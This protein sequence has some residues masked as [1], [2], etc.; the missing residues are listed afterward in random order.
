MQMGVILVTF[1]SMDDGKC[2]PCKEVNVRFCRCLVEGSV[3]RLWLKELRVGEKLWY[4]Q[5]IR[6]FWYRVITRLAN[7]P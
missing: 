2:D 4:Y 7:Q 3:Q 5:G 6:L 1:I